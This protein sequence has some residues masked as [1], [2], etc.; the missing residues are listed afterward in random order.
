MPKYHRYGRKE[1]K[2]LK[3][4]KKIDGI[5]PMIFLS[6]FGTVIWILK[7]ICLYFYKEVFLCYIKS[8]IKFEGKSYLMKIKE[9]K[10]YLPR[11]FIFNLIL[12]F[13]WIITFFMNN[14]YKLFI[15][16]GGFICFVIFYIIF[17]SCYYKYS[18]NKTGFFDDF[19]IIFNFIKKEWFNQNDTALNDNTKEKIM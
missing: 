15:I 8:H 7:Y 5:I 13:F 18:Y 2:S 14:E 19:I 17:W 1:T 10:S 12:V 4:P 6:L 16:K 9:Y 3:F 11:I